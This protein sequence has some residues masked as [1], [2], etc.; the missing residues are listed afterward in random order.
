MCCCRRMGRVG[1][2]SRWWG[3]RF[4]C[5]RWARRCGCARRRNFAERLAE[6]GVRVVPVGASVRR[7]PTGQ[8]PPTAC[9]SARPS[10]AAQSARSPRRPTGCDALVATGMM[11]A[12]AGVRS[13]AEK[14]GIRLRVR[15][16]PAAHAAV[17]APP[18]ARRTGPAVPAGVTDNRAL[19]DWT[20]RTSTRCSARRS[21]ATGRRSACRRW[22]TSATTS[23]TDRAVA[24]DG[25]GPGPVAGER[26]TST[27]CR[28]ARGSCPTSARCRPTWR[29]S[30]TPAR[31][32]CTSASAAC[33]CT[34]GRTSPRWPSRRSGAQGRRAVVARG[35]AGLA[36]IDDGDDCFV[37]GEVNQQ[38]LFRRV[39]AVVHHGGAGTTTTAAR[40]GA[41]QVVVP[42]M[43]DQPYWA[44]RV[45]ELG[46][47]AAHDGPTPTV[48]SLAAA[49][50]TALAPGDP[51]RSDRRGR[52]D[53][54]R[55]GDGG[56]EAA[57]R[58]TEPR[59]HTKK[60]GAC[61]N[62]GVRR[63]I[64]SPSATTWPG[65]T[66]GS[67]PSARGSRSGTARRCGAHRRP[68]RRRHS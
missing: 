23:I 31:R 59:D 16:L 15:D 47:G 13:V 8:A 2:S 17:A 39:A 25:P 54:H 5:G 18:A 11:P 52:H 53:P 50:E 19:W 48:E 65:S 42:Q 41:P 9:L 67:T 10:V 27:S 60:Q 12:A 45:A 20:H 4:G 30:W 36:V 26:R 64:A 32:R 14:L 38:A 68:G 51:R 66:R 34:I 56:R 7:W 6:V 55:R 29:R 40:A 22:T 37:V 28:P 58:T 33:P 3:W 63:R 62:S 49:L 1:T 24:G 57:A 43:A 35:W 46:I 44:G 61:V 21:T